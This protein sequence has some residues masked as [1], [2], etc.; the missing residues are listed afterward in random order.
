ML[1]GTPHDAMCEVPAKLFDARASCARSPTLRLRLLRVP[2]TAAASDLLE[3]HVLRLL[4]VEREP[5]S[6]GTLVAELGPA[7][8]GPLGTSLSATT[9]S[10]TAWS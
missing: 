9:R 7:G 10:R 5:L 4:A 8:D 2:R 3:Q 6:I 1:N